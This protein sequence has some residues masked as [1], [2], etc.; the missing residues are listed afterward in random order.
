LLDINIEYVNGILFIRLDGKI[1]LTNS[2]NICNNIIDIIRQGG[3]KYVVFNLVNLFIEE[4]VTL[5]DECNKI[6]K[7]NNGLMM[8]CGLDKSI[9]KIISSD[10]EY[11]EKVEDELTVLRRFSVC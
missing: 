5:F 9:D 3:I 4:R 1:N 6:I 7:E 10:Y 8:I 2:V 11:C